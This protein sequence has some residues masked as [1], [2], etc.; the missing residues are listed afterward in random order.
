MVLYRYYSGNMWMRVVV[1]QFEVF[2][3]EVIDTL[4]IRINFH[5]RQCAWF[6]AKL[7]FDLIQVVQIDMASPSVWINS[8]AFSPVTCAIICSSSAYDAILNGTPRNISALR[9]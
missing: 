6:A 8:P 9:W 2:E 3:L 5:L 1:H 4:H 7:Q